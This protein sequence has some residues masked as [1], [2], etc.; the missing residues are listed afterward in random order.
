MLTLQRKPGEGIHEWRN[1]RHQQIR[2]YLKALSTDEILKAVGELI[3]ADPL[4]AISII[5]PEQLDPLHRS[6]RGK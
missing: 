3:D 5:A 6:L 4:L 1:R 2:E